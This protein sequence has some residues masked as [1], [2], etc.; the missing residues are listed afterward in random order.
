[1]VADTALEAFIRAAQAWG[2]EIRGAE[3][4]LENSI[5]TVY[6]NRTMRP[7]GESS[8]GEQS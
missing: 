7:P 4:S 5:E 1:M 2:P 6:A 3:A 8:D